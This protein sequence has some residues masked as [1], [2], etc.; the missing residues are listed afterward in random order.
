MK[1]VFPFTS[2]SSDS[3]V[4][5]SSPCIISTTRMARSHIEEPLLRRFLKITIQFIVGHDSEVNNIITERIR[6]Q[7]CQ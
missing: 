2:N 5:G 1:G 3:K 7:E 4:C 6:A